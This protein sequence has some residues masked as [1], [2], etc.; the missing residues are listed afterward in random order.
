MANEIGNANGVSGKIVRDRH[1]ERKGWKSRNTTPLLGLK[2]TRLHEWTPWRSRV[3][4]VLVEE[5]LRHPC[6]Q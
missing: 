3:E 2:T 5:G 4:G 1:V 6:T